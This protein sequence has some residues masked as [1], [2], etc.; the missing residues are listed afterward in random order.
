MKIHRSN[1]SFCCC[2]LLL[3]AV[4]LLAV[5]AAAAAALSE[6]HT[7]ATTNGAIRQPASQAASDLQLQQQLQNQLNATAG[8]GDGESRN[9]AEIFSPGDVGKFSSILHTR[10]LTPQT[11]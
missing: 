7:N 8:N 1:E 3:L 9:S 11:D 2:W 4:A 5:E 6:T 10:T